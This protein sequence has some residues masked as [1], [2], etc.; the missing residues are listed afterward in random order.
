MG[1]GFLWTDPFFNITV[2]RDEH[3]AADLIDAQTPYD[4]PRRTLQNLVSQVARSYLLVDNST[5]APVGGTFSITRPRL[6]VQ[7]VPLR[8]VRAL[9]VVMVIFSGSLWWFMP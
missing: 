2:T 3:D 5:S 1:G 8:I 6:I 7:Q 4:A 9:L